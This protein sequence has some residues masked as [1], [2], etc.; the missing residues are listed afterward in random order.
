MLIVLLVVCYLIGSIPIAWLI[1]KLATGK[2]IR[3]LGS[4]NVGVLNTGISV[5]R[6]PALLVFFGE[7]AKGAL[8]VSVARAM[9]EGESL[10]TAAALA[11]VIGTRW[12]IWLCGAGG[13]GNTA[14]MT[15]LLLISWHTVVCTFATWFTA[16]YISRSSFIATR[17]T[18]VVW[19]L[20][21]GLLT[22]LWLSALLG[23][24]FSL[25]FATTHRPETDD[26]L[27]INAQWGSLKGFL[28]SPRRK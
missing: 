17:I 9:G 14:A 23:L 6:L 15:A 16:R 19:P 4:G 8:A 3:R 18:L 20:I 28:T 27:L 7:A 22:Q 13:R 2:D 10:A 5:G 1:T 25:L 21:F 24:I 11:A 12:S 26:H